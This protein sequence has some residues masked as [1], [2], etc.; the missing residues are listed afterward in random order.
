MPLVVP[1]ADLTLEQR[2]IISESVGNRN[3]YWIDGPP[4]S[5]KTTISLHLANNFVGEQVVS[6]LVLI[7]NNSL[8]GYLKSSFEELGLS[9]NVTISTKDKFFWAL[10]REHGIRPINNRKYEDKYN[11]LLDSLEKKELIKT[12][13]IA[14]LDEIQDFHKK[15]WDILKRLVT[16]FIVLGD[17][18]QGIY[19]TDLRKVD[20]EGTCKPKLLS[21]IFRF[22][23][24]IASLLNPFNN[25]DKNLH[26]KVDVVEDIQPL[27]LDV[28]KNDVH[29]KIKDLIHA[30]STDGGRIAIISI[31]KNSL[32]YLSKYLTDNNV[33]HV[34]APNPSDF[35][36]HDFSE[37]TPVLITSASA[38]GLEFETVIAFGFDDDEKAVYGFRTYGGL[39]ENIYVC[40]SRAKQYLYL[41]R[42]E[43]SIPEIINLQIDDSA[44]KEDTRAENHNDFY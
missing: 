24:K 18:D 25:N 21:V 19:S 10:G 9:D 37:N 27:I 38:K 33:T 15:E 7:Y 31:G 16:R 28:N 30:R 44:S 36:N 42:T 35:Q 23:K 20:L 14:I 43:N 29:K 40:L 1:F 4:G 22:G 2:R 12:Y 41:I 6:P 11:F 5:G 32:K 8:L 3:S 26:E 17:F 13:D 34:H 39:N